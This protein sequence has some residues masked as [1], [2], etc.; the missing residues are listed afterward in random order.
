[1]TKRLLEAL[2][3]HRKTNLVAIPKAVSHSLG[4]P[5][6]LYGHPLDGVEFHGFRKEA[7]GESHEPNGHAM[8]LGSPILLTDGDPHLPWELIGKLMERESRNQADHTL[9][10]AFRC[11]SKTV[12]GVQRSIRELIKTSRKP[13]DLAI[14]LHATHGGRGHSLRA[15]LC[16]TRYAARFQHGVGS[17]ALGC[18]LGQDT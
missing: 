10:Y 3:R 14:S 18:G 12:V 7:V 2:N 4:D 11:L 5:E 13:E 16:E 9:G 17:S 15:Q 1:L 6:N 8:P